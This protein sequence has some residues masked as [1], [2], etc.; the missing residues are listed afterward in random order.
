VAV[1]AVLAVIAGV[2]IWGWAKY[3]RN[4]LDAGTYLLTALLMNALLK[5]GVASEA[6]RP[7]S[8]ERRDGTLELLLSTPLSVK[9][10]LHGQA[11]ALAR[12][13]LGPFLIVAA[14]EIGFMLAGLSELSLDERGDWLR[15][16]IAG[17]AMLA[18]DGIALYWVGMWRA[19]S[20]RAPKR[21]LAETVGIVLVLPWVGFAMFVVFGAFFGVEPI[22][23]VQPSWTAVLSAWCLFGFAT[24]A[25][26]SVWARHILL[27]EF[28]QRAAERY[29]TRVSWWRRLLG[30]ESAAAGAPRAG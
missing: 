25:A 28:R 18:A 24:D 20:A 11:L 6:T 22:F 4:W 19:I 16:W 13:F 21:A 17:L 9:E 15:T 23:G 8:E 1:W 26:F 30:G 5:L 2:W 29:A 27:S 7:L 3:S 12:V 14:L 10:I